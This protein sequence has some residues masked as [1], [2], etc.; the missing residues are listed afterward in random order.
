MRNKFRKRRTETMKEISMVDYIKAYC[1]G[2]YSNFKLKMASRRQVPFYDITYYE[3]T[4]R[5][6]LVVDKFYIGD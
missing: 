3:D 1:G 6:L 4:E 2:K 5:R